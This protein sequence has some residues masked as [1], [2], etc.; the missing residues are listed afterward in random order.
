MRGIGAHNAPSMII[1]HFRDFVKGFCEK[2]ERGIQFFE[3]KNRAVGGTRLCF[4]IFGSWSCVSLV[5]G[6]IVPCKQFPWMFHPK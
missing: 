4:V 3:K 2:T 1:L 6:R 5:F